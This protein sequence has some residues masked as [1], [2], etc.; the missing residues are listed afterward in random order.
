MNMR[1]AAVE[2]PIAELL[3]LP[4][5][6]ARA[7]FLAGRPELETPGIVEE[8]CEEA[9]T[10]WRADTLKALALA[11]AAREIAERI[12][13]PAALAQAWRATANALYFRGQNAASVDA[14]AT[15]MALFEQ[16]GD[17]TEI[18][19]TASASIQPL[20][21][22]GA[23]DRA[24]RA[25]DR[26][27]EIFARQKNE[28]RLAH[29]ETNVGNL[30]H[31]QDRFAE[32]LE[33]YERACACYERHEDVEGM[34]VAMHN[35]A[36]SLI[37]LN[38]FPRALA[39]Y[40][41]SRELAERH[42]MP[43]LAA[44]AD[45]N[46][47]YLYF[48]RGEYG[49]AIQMLRDVRESCQKV[50]DPYHHALCYL[51]LSEIYLELNLSTEAEEMAGEAMTR[52]QNLGMGYEAAKA[53][54]FQAMAAG[55]QGKG[56]LATELFEKA[57]AMF[58]A[59]QNQVW[60]WLLD[61]YRALIL[62]HEGRLFEARRLCA[63]A[64]EF[65]V[66]AKLRS[67]AI[68][69]R[70]LLARLALRTDDLEG[71]ARECRA[72]LEE[73]QGLEAPAL[74]FQ[75]HFLIGQVEE[76]RGDQP[77]SFESY[78]TAR[79]SL[80]NLRSSIRGEELRIAFM[81]NKLEVYEAL[82]SLCLT[83]GRGSG[84]E[85]LAFME[86]AKSRSLM[87][88]LFS[89]SH[90]FPADEPGQSELVRKIR[91]L[92]EELNWYY[93]RIEQETLKNEDRSPDRIQR[94]QA[95]ARARENEFLRALHEM[96]APEPP[97]AGWGTSAPVSLEALR[98]ALPPGAAM[99]EYFSVRERIVAAFI[100]ADGLEIVPLTPLSRV[101]NL[102]SLLQF[103]LAKFRLSPDY[104]SR[105]HEVLLQATLSHLHDLHQE[106]LAPLRQHWHGD[107][108]IVV[109]HG[110]L[111]YLP[112]HALYDGTQYLIDSVRVSYAPSATV[113]QH[114]HQKTA[115]NAGPSLVMGIPD[116]QAPFIL[117]EVL[118]VA[119]S[120]PEPE[121]FVGDRATVETLRDRGTLA[122][123][124]HIA[125]HGTFRADNPMFSSIRLGQSYLSLYDLYHLKLPA[126]LITLSGCATG[127]NVVAAGDELLGLVRG[128]LHA[129]AQS[130]LLTLWEVH[131][132]STAEFMRAFYANLQESS[133]K[134][135]ALQGAMQSLR[136]AYPHPYYWAP[137]FLVGKV[138]TDA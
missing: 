104:V 53:L 11:E 131:D 72:A 22:L 62:F 50:G 54:A 57:R 136:K 52:F 23:Y 61:L 37:C 109:P 102:L 134:P 48:F 10:T 77:R 96:P 69:C 89:S 71:A 83:R 101:K 82:V 45:Y 108:L 78:Q 8:L 94:L 43:L 123:R 46:I 33:C 127:L 75:I 117:D 2:N 125:A 18:A 88:L 3:R 99:A 110:I 63:G 5:A 41:Q 21:L 116:P 129:G 64:L 60:P 32:A 130:L 39:T 35:A 133:D 100:T 107:H 58:V 98:R 111:H 24:H 119:S 112:F 19:R 73:L 70:L 113:Y 137:F 87:D 40:Q 128:L 126:E 106:L 26:A 17:E 138:F 36:V 132:R 84:E 31:R 76:A 20:I 7:A 68:L 86:Q 38:D 9:R 114:C 66:S 122:R 91:G 95:Q 121:L 74:A 1:A 93:H 59:E 44:Q 34:A 51:D 12:E 6:A 90:A 49:R 13:D 118:A 85:A 4:D 42:N 124:I 25:A 16:L 92:R 67:K 97:L 81:K 115:N 120:L 14:H 15:A 30:L 47:A 55:Q 80:E 56:F 65:F 135:A 29:L 27:R 79:Q 28:R 103:Q 105:F